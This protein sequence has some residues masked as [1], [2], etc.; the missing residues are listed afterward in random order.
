MH[1]YKKFA[2][3]ACLL[4]WICQ[5]FTQEKEYKLLDKTSNADLDQTF[6]LRLNKTRPGLGM[7]DSLF[8][9]VKGKFTVYRFLATY[10]GQSFTGQEKEFHDL[11]IVKTDEQ[12]KVIK[13][14]QYTLEWAEPPLETD[15][16]LSTAKDL[17][18]KDG[19][20]VEAFGFERP[21][22]EDKDKRVKDVGVVQF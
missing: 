7:L 11:L 20:K 4:L 19:L 8:M 6:I 12:G 3:I 1:Y 17:V 5:A 15:L 2:L 9:P 16:Y 21:W 10:R 14:Y 22:Y 13:A 18:L